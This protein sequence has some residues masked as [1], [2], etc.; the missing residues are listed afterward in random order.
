MP[1]ISTNADGRSIK[2]SVGV[3][4]TFDYWKPAGASW[5]RPAKHTLGTA[6]EGQASSV[7]ACVSPNGDIATGLIVGEEC[8]QVSILIFFRGDIASNTIPRLYFVAASIG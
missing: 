1:G 6:P 2:L 8:F 7:A 3:T 4:D 5:L